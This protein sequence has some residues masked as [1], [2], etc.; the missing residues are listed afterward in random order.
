[1]RIRMN[2]ALSGRDFN[3]AA[4]HEYDVPAALGKALT[5]DDR[6]DRVEPDRQGKRTGRAKT[7]RTEAKPGDVEER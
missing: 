2:V 7:E 1:M 6:A 5:S 3:Y 4:G